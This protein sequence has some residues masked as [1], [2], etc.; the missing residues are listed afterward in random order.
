[1]NKRSE[2]S[3]KRMEEKF[4]DMNKRVENSDKRME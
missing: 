3:D 2:N 4:N 1:M